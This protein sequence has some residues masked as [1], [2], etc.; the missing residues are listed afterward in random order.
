MQ[1]QLLSLLKGKY[2]SLT[3]S[4]N[5][6]AVDYTDAITAIRDGY[7]YTNCEWVSEE[8]KSL[9]LLNN[10]VWEIQWYPDT[11]VGSHSVAGTTL[12]GCLKYIFGT[13]ETQNH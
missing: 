6:H 13:Y 4:Y 11:P 9:A 7:T 12:N 1:E 3:I 5:Q 8:E 2:S 10:S